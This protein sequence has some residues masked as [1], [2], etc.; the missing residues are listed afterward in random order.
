MT[1]PERLLWSRLRKN[2]EGIKFRRQHPLG[3]YVVDFFCSRART[4]IEIDGIA[5]DMGDR[6]SRDARRDA[7][8]SG[9][10]FRIFRIPASEVL[11][12]FDAV[13]DAIFRACRDVPPPSALRAATSPGGGGVFRQEYSQNTSPIGGGGPPPSGGGGGG[14]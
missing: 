5:H 6:P 8:L 10:G 13:A 2:P 14:L 3:E 11:E 9:M 12:D 7:A 1:L 4:V